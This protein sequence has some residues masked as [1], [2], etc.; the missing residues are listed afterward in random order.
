MSFH[1][2]VKI[3]H[4]TNVQIFFTT[5]DS[6]GAPA[7]LSGTPVVSAYENA[8]TIQITAG[9][10]LTV[11]FDTV[12]GLNL[13]AVAVTSANG[14][15]VAANYTL[16]ITTGAVDG[17]SVVGYVVGSFS[18]EN[19]NIESISNGAITASTIAADAIGASELAADAVAE[20]ADAVWDELQSGHVGAGTFGEVATETA[21]ILVNTETTLQA[22]LDGIQADTENIQAR[23]PA[24]LVSG[25]IDASVGAMAADVVTA[26]AI[27]TG[28]IDAD[29]IAADAIGASE[30]AADAVTEI[31][32]GIGGGIFT[33]QMTEAYADDGVAPTPAQALFAILQRLTEFS[34]SG[35]TITVKK[36]DGSTNAYVLT[37]DDPI[38]PTSSTRSS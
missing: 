38:D 6:T 33:T 17:V 37:M 21:A 13:V 34:I 5:V 14:Y 12:T 30:L 11:D 19:R 35:A 31:S 1:G 28:A 8:S 36:I 23:L 4:S 22:E 18:V 9:I 32:A 2:D 7:T 25:R 26:A 24:A 29:A 10:V 20:I 27:A 15:E 16:V 3:D